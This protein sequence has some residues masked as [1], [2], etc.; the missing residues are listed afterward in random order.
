MIAFLEAL[1]AAKH[2]ATEKKAKKWKG[3]KFKVHHTL[4]MK[5]FV[6]W[7]RFGSLSEECHPPLRTYS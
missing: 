5:A 1:H 2:P 7:L 3:P 6:V 4:E